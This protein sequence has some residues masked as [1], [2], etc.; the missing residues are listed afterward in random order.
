MKENRK[1]FVFVIGKSAGMNQAGMIKGFNALVS[2]Q[3]TIDD[4]SDYTLMFFNDA[5]K[6][7]A[8]GKSMKEMRKYNVKTYVPKGKSAIYDAIGTAVDAVG[9][10]LSETKED[11]RPSLVSV[12]I[13]GE[14]DNA[15]V[16]YTKEDICEMVKLQKYTYSWDFVFF[17]KNGAELGI[18]KGGELAD[19]EEA[20]AKV[21]EYMTSVR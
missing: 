13:F 16:S 20:F 2:A 19:A 1:E 9:K 11:E 8:D 5:A 15:S 6:L 12:I 17:G 21:S 4:E 3:K 10:R 14:E 18:N 7:S